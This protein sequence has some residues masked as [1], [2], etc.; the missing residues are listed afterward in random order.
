MDRAGAGTV[1]MGEM[2]DAGLPDRIGFSLDLLLPV[3]ELNDKYKIDFDGWQHYRASPK[4]EIKKGA[5]TPSILWIF[6]DELFSR[7][8]KNDYRHRNPNNPI[9]HLYLI[10]ELIMHHLDLIVGHL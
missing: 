2:Q 7:N 5:A 9:D 1:D 10:A 3:I 6:A 8:Y 4:N